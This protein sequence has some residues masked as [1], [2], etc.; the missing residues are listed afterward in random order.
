MDQAVTTDEPS[1]ALAEL[2]M[3]AMLACWRKPRGASAQEV[4][5]LAPLV[6]DAYEAAAGLKGDVQPEVRPMLESLIPCVEYRRGVAELLATRN[7]Y[8]DQLLID[9]SLWE[10]VIVYAMAEAAGIRPIKYAVK[11]KRSPRALVRRQTPVLAKH[12]PA[13]KV[14][15]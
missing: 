12:H 6:D 14:R 10:N 2:S 5:A 8:A 11:L 9:H 4:D 7:R 1:L 3:A 15:E 13:A